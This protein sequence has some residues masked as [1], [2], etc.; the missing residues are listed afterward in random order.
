MREHDAVKVPGEHVI[1]LV[2]RRAT[3]R[4]LLKL[5][6]IADP[7]SADRTQAWKVQLVSTYDT[8]HRKAIPWLCERTPFH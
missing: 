8:F 1:D 3:V 5:W 6:R 4:E 7:P 2:A